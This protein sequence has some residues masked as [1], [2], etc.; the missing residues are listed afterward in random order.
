MAGIEA[1]E[2]L[3]HSEKFVSAAAA[4]SPPNAITHP[5]ATMLRTI[6]MII[7]HPQ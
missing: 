2:L 1:T 3:L 4:R 7:V 5:T 6:R